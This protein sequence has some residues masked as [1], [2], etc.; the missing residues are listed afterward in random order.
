MTE[1]RHSG[2]T[3]D[4][5]YR[6]RDAY[7][8][9]AESLGRDYLGLLNL[10]STD[11]AYHS[12][13]SEPPRPNYFRPHT[14]RDAMAEYFKSLLAEWRMVEFEPAEYVAQGSTIIMRGH[15]EWIFRLTGKTCLTMEFNC[16]HFHNGKAV[17]LYHLFDTAAML[18]SMQP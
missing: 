8:T 4:D 14:G 12:P 1:N 9:F 13:L 11:F 10:M 16:W 18:E 3:V 17:A 7:S 6:L 5:V 15:S 2:V